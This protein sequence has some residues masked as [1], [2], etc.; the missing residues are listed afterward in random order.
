[1][2]EMTPIYYN[3][4]M[5]NYDEILQSENNVTLFAS[6]STVQFLIPY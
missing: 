6:L 5:Y 1:M 2:S 4:K 3:L